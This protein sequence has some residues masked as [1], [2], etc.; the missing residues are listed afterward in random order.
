MDPQ[1][2]IPIAGTPS[3]WPLFPPI[4]PTGS[5]TWPAVKN[6]HLRCNSRLSVDLE[7]Y[8]PVRRA[9]PVNSERTDDIMTRRQGE[10]RQAVR[11]DE[12]SIGRLHQHNL[13][14]REVPV[15]PIYVCDDLAEARFWRSG[16]EGSL[17]WE[18]VS[19]I[20]V[21]MGGVS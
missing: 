4:A 12:Q 17:G 2:A 10:F 20:V 9:A 6:I 11:V 14:A 21:F 19:L 8:R 3:G 15:I 13:P 18:G 16:L 7:F 5:Q 1:V